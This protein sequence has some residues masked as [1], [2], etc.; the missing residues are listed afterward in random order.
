MFNAEIYSNVLCYLYD[1]VLQIAFFLFVN[2]LKPQIVMLY[3][4]DLKTTVC[5]LLNE[6]A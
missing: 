6:F 4:K 5:V 1:L 3:H 2:S